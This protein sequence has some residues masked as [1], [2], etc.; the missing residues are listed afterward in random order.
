VG[1]VAVPHQSGFIYLVTTG[2]GQ[3]RLIT[4]S[5]ADA[6]G[7]DVW[8]HNDAVGRTRLAVDADRSANRAAADRKF[9]KPTLGRIS[10]DDANYAV[11][12]EHL[13]APSTAVACSCRGKQHSHSGRAQAR[14]GIWEMSQ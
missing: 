10:P 2:T 1:E 7:R 14:T 5:A 8:H 4:I 9:C 13:R 12:R 3:H 6:I 11:Y